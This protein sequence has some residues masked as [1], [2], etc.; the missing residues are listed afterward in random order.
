YDLT[1]IFVEEPWRHLHA[2]IKQATIF[3]TFVGVTYFIQ[4][5]VGFSLWA[6]FLMLQLFVVQRRTF[7]ADLPQAAMDDQHLGSAIAFLCG[8][9]WIGRHH[10]RR[11][12]RH[13]VMGLSE[14]ERRQG[15]VCYRVP[16]L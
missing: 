2:N 8:I 14:D 5:R 4:S 16:A 10:W 7:G 6:T 11:V 12:V 9:L 3:F 1:G 15:A 13:L